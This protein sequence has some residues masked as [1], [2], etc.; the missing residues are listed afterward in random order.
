MRPLDVLRHNRASLLPL[1]AGALILVILIPLPTWLLDILLITSIT[2]SAL[3]MMT[4]I[5]LT[6]PLE[7]SVFPS[8]LLGLTLFRL[9]LNTATTRLIL[10]NAQEGTAA[11]GRVVQ[12]F[13]EFVA[14]GSLAVG[15]ISTTFLPI[16]AKYRTMAPGTM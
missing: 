14:A 5:Y 6:N 9:V 8:L 10:T 11:A 16:C 1:A 12:T 15:V 3:V 7:L 2:C 13:G 4:V